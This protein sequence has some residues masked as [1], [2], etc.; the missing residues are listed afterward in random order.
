MATANRFLPTVMVQGRSQNPPGPSRRK[1]VSKP[2]AR[3]TSV[4]RKSRLSRYAVPAGVSLAH[5]HRAGIADSALVPVWVQ[6]F[7]GGSETEGLAE[8]HLK[9]QEGRLALG[10]ESWMD[11]IKKQFGLSHVDYGHNAHGPKPMKPPPQ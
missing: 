8:L 10:V 6:S 4:A 3:S 2:P 7:F 5:W 11:A 1:A 9:T